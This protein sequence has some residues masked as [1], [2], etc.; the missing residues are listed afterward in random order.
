MQACIDLALTHTEEQDN[1]F[2][3]F[4]VCN[5][6]KNEHGMLRLLTLN[7][8]LTKKCSNKVKL[9][10]PTGIYLHSIPSWY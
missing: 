7:L 5:N 9:L 3:Q 10:L 2:Q 1:N 8:W 6:Y 4:N